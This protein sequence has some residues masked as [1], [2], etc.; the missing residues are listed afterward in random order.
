[1]LSAIENNP[2]KDTV[3]DLNFL[4]ISYK[5]MTE[6]YFKNRPAIFRQNSISTVKKMVDEV[7]EAV[8]IE[9][10]K[11]VHR[12]IVKMEMKGND[13]IVEAEKKEIEL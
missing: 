2:L 4:L 1:M 3:E 8:N 12:I 7:I 5:N 11:D 6:E 9:H 13:F 10:G